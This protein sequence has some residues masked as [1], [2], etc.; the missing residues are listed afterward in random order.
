MEKAGARVFFSGL[1]N[2]TVEKHASEKLKTKA[3]TILFFIWYEIK[4][5]NNA[6]KSRYKIQNVMR[7]L[8]RIFL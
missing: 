8:P 7:N 6:L 4:K 1:M 3:L 2:Q 5:H